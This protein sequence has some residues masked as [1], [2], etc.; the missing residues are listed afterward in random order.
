[1]NKCMTAGSR[2]KW[3]TNLGNLS[4]FVLRVFG[5]IFTGVNIFLQTK[6][7]FLYVLVHIIYTPKIT[8]TSKEC[9]WHYWGCE[10][11]KTKRGIY[12]STWLLCLIPLRAV[13]SM[14]ETERTELSWACVVSTLSVRASSFLSSTPLFTEALCCT[15][16]ISSP[17]SW[18]CVTY[19]QEHRCMQKNRCKNIHIDTQK[20]TKHLAHIQGAHESD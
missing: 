10:W 2:N 15:F 5:V 19:T 18:S 4:S 20:N 11:L 7:N 1:M 16:S 13:W 6:T 14:L 3:T 9:K 8:K 17:S 12:S